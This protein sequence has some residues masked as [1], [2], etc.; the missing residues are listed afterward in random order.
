MA[1][2]LRSSA[3]ITSNAGIG[4]SDQFATNYWGSLED[5]KMFPIPFWQVQQL[6]GATA[7]NEIALRVTNI[8]NPNQV[9]AEWMAFPSALADTLGTPNVEPNV[10]YYILP[11]NVYNG[12]IP[13]QTPPFLPLPG[14]KDATPTPQNNI[15]WGRIGTDGNGNYFSFL[16]AAQC[17]IVDPGGG[18]GG[19]LTG[20]RVPAP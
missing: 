19:A 6:I 7:G 3:F 17:S 16:L 20:L 4:E 15:I 13:S 18:G 9:Y 10:R 2:I 1:Q 5:E 14:L 8:E 11:D 12:P